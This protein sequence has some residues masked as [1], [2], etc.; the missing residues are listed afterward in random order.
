MLLTVWIVVPL[1]YLKDKFKR[2]RMLK[3]FEK[4]LVE[5]REEDGQT[6]EPLDEGV[7]RALASLVKSVVRKYR[8]GLVLEA[9]VAVF[10]VVF[11]FYV[12]DFRQPMVIVNRHTPPLLLALAVCWL[13]DRAFVRFCA[14][15]KVKR[16]EADHE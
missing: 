12:T 11:F 10:S 7:A 15:K 16:E 5:G 9:I 6:I 13:V 3:Q 4:E 1:G 2:R 14:I 8:A